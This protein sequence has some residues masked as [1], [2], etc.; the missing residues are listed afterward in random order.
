MEQEMQTLPGELDSIVA[1]LDRGK[2]RSLLLRLNQD[3]DK[4]LDELFAPQK[5]MLWLFP[6]VI[7][8]VPPSIRDIT[9][10]DLSRWR[11]A[12]KSE[13]RVI[14]GNGKLEVTSASRLAAQWETA[15]SRI[16]PVAQ[17]R[18]YALLSWDHYQKLL[19]E[20]GKLISGD[21]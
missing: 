19:D 17:Q 13:V 16:T 2:W 18:G 5:N 11:A 21:D 10:E 15:V 12:H 7:T 20:I 1:C 6:M 9:S 4:L 3:F 8:F 14:V